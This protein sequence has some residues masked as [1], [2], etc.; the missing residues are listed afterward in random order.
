MTSD[1]KTIAVGAMSPIPGLPDAV[2]EVMSSS[3][4]A[5]FATTTKDGIPLDTPTYCFT[6]VDGLSIDVATGLA[7]PTK[8]ERA[9]NNPKVGLLLEGGPDR[10]IVSIA[11]FAAVRDRDIQANANRYIRETV[12]YDQ[13]R[14]HEVPWNLRREAVWY[15]SRIF[16]VCTPKRIL[17]WPNA[18]A[19]EAEPGRWFCDSTRQFTAS[20]PAPAAQPSPPASWP[21]REWQ[22]R[23]DELMSLGIASH[24]T[25]L[26]AEGF[27]L[28]FPCRPAARTRDGFDLA[29]PAGAPWQIG[30][31][32]S[33]SFSGAATF[34]GQVMPGAGHANF[35]VERIMPDLP[36]VQDPREVFAPSVSTRA[37][38]M[39]RLE[40]ELARRGQTIP[41]IFDEPPTP[42]PGSLLRAARLSHLMS[43]MAP[44]KET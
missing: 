13:L 9:R 5:E 4:V 44:P 37:A 10:P 8:A 42:T 41:A 31:R 7:Y 24:L 39:G 12:A 2:L 32:A 14:V 29:I 23:A 34:I 6:G 27:P 36:M 40:K 22:E 19:M 35:T 3:I 25:L 21:K 17:W 30:G 28:P 15:W 38:L 16:V 18:A 33:L 20:D 11:A 43:Q 1:S 26:D